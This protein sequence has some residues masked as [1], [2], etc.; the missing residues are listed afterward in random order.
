M[1]GVFSALGVE[2]TLLSRRFRLFAVGA[3]VGTVLVLLAVG[4][5][6]FAAYLALLAALAPWQAALIVG[7]GALVFGGL[8]LLV[9]IKALNRA[10]DQIQDAVKTNALVRAAPIAARLVISSPRLIAAAA[11]V[12]A[13]VVALLRAL[14]ERQKK[15][16]S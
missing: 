1:S 14:N 7:A 9:A 16:E 8:L 13:A 15:S 6:A 11:A 2:T 10:A 5:M 3:L 12:V 4:F